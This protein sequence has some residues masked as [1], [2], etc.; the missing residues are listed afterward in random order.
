MVI[1][2]EF[3]DSEFRKPYDALRKAGH[4][5]TLVGARAGETLDGKK[6]KESAK[7]ELAAGAADPTSFDAMAI[8]GGNSPDHLRTDE[9]VVG[10]V[11]AFAA[12]GRP[13]A[14]VCHGPQL[15]IEVNA[16]VGRTLTSWPSVRKDLENAGARWVDREVV[17]DGNLITSRKPDDLPAFSEALLAA[18]PGA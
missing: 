3:E 1:G 14:A 11:R 7:V 17:V 2:A 16:V 5:V 6:G 10:F 18:L 9:D 15:L 4:E 8:P 12:T 13:I